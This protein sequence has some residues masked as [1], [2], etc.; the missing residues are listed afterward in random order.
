MGRAP[1]SGNQSTAQTHLDRVHELNLIRGGHDNDIGQGSKVGEIE[2]SMMRGPVVAN[3]TG[4]VEDKSHRQLLDG[5][6][7]HYLR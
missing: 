6:I 3:E 2:A 5:N 4:T 1:L 7:V